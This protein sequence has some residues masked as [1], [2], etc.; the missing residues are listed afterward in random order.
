MKLSDLT[1]LINIIDEFNIDTGLLSVDIAHIELLIADLLDSYISTNPLNFSN[2]NFEDKIKYYVID[3]LMTVLQSIYNSDTLSE[4]D[5][6]IDNMY[7][8]V[9]IVYFKNSYPKR[10]HKDSFIRKLPCVDTIT[11][12]INNIKEKPQPDQRTSEWY[13]FR[14]NLI[15]ASSAWKVFKSQSTINQLVVE[16]CQPIDHSKYD[17][18]NTETAMHHG[19][20]FED[21]SIQFYEN[22]YS[23]KVEDFGCIQHDTY[24]FIGASPDGINV[25]KTSSR[26]GR[27]LEIKNP[28]SRVL[29]GTPKEDY[30]IQMQLQMETCNLNECDFLETVFKEYE[31]EDSFH[32]DGNFT[33]TEEGKLKGILVYF[34]KNSKPH[35][36][37]MPLK[38][39]K[40]Q[41]DEWYTSIMCKNENLTWIKNIYWKLEDYSC[42]LVLRNK[43]WFEHAVPYIGNVW[44]TIEK[45]RETGYSHRLP[46]KRKRSNSINNNNVILESKCIININKLQEQIIYVNTELETKNIEDISGCSIKV[47]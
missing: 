23:T 13:N 9:S 5:D 14:H 24:K 7:D 29:T 33:Y 40:E 28:T 45:E 11:E 1:N 27:M 31:D 20:K 32:N 25:D 16:K 2:Y 26:Y 18:V 36:E 43:Y 38:Y 21:V 22:M 8:K 47:N 3:N 4:I 35:Y 34:I 37:Y 44:N 30:W 39:T 6:E 17:K 12:K 41:Y 10:S 15:T 46:T 19:N 42:I